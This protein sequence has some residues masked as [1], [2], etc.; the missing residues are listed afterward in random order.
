MAQ[1]T[2]LCVLTQGGGF[3]RPF[4]CG[5]KMLTDGFGYGKMKL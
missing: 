2:V 1:G 3:G 5:K 4:C